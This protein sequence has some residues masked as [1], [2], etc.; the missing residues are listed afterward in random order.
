[1]N[2]AVLKTGNIIIKWLSYSKIFSKF[3]EILLI[4]RLLKGSFEFFTF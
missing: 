2:K 1:M 4:Q 3:S